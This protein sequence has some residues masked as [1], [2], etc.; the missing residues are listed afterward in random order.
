MS[1]FTTSDNVKLSYTEYGEGVPIVMMAGYGGAAI[2]HMCHMNALVNS[3][4]RVILF[5]RRSHGES[6]SPLQGQHLCRHAVDVHELAEH[7]GL[8]NYILAGHSMGASTIYA[9]FSIYGS[10]NLR[11]AICI[12]QTPKIVNDGEWELGMKNCTLENMGHFLD[13]AAF[14]IDLIENVPSFDVKRTENLLREHFWADWRDVFPTIDIPVLFIAGN[15]ND[16]WDPEQ[17]RY[18]AERCPKGQYVV[19]SEGGHF[20][21]FVVPAECEAAILKFARELS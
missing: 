21:P 8:K 10:E 9:Y 14:K 12:D 4:F 2:N 11:G 20:A 16:F 3:G 1:F 5:D 18:C 17:A 13:D 7:L 15:H 19:L 6:E